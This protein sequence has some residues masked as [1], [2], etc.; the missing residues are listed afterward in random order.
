MKVKGGPVGKRKDI[1][2]GD[3]GERESRG[4]NKNNYICKKML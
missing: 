1:T 4:Y 3:G 2:R